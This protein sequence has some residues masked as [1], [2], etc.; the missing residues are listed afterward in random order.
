MKTHLILILSLAL[1]FRAYSVNPYLDVYELPE[2]SILYQTDFQTASPGEALQPGWTIEQ[3]TATIVQEDS[4]NLPCLRI[5]PSPQGKF[6]QVTFKLDPAPDVAVLFVD[7]VIKPVAFAEEP[8]EFID[9]SGSVTGAFRLVKEAVSDKNVAALYVLNGNGERGGDWMD[10][11]VTFPL[12]DDGRPLHWMRLTF[13]Q[14]FSVSENDDE[15]TDNRWDLW[16]N[17]RLSAANLGYYDNANADPGRISLLGHR[18]VPLFLERL[19]VS[20]ENPLFADSNRNGLSDKYESVYGLNGRDEDHDGDGLANVQ[21]FLKRTNPVLADSDRDGLNDGDELM[22]GRNPLDRGDASPAEAETYDQ[23]THWGPL[24]SFASAGEI[25]MDTMTSCS[26]SV[27]SFRLDFNSDYLPT[28]PGDSG[29]SFK[30]SEIEVYEN[31]FKKL[32]ATVLNSTFDD[33]NDESGNVTL[34]SWAGDFSFGYIRVVGETK[35]YGYSNPD[36]PESYWEDIYKTTW[37]NRY[38]C[39]PSCDTCVNSVDFNYDLGNLGI[40]GGVAKI[41]VKRERIS[42]EI[43]RRSSLS[44][45]GPMDE[46]H[47]QFSPVAGEHDRRKEALDWVRTATQFTTFTDFPN[48]N[49]YQIK[50]YALDQIDSGNQAQGE[51]FQTITVFDPDPQA[52]GG[53]KSLRIVEEGE[54]TASKE[55]RSYQSDEGEVW[56]LFAG[57]PSTFL[58]QPLKHERLVES[59]DSGRSENGGYTRKNRPRKITRR[60]IS[61]WDFSSNGLKI[62]QV[63]ETV[64]E[65]FP[66]GWQLVEES[67]DPDGEDLRTVYGFRDPSEVDMDNRTRGDDDVQWVQYPD[68]NWEWYGYDGEGN[69]NRIVRPLGNAPRPDTLPTTNQGFRVTTHEFEGPGYRLKTTELT[70][71]TV[72]RIIF[73]DYQDH[74]TRPVPGEWVEREIVAYKAGATVNDPDNDVTTT[75]RDG[76]TNR[77]LRIE[78][79]DGRVTANQY[80]ENGDTLI[81]ETRYQLPSGEYDEEA[82]QVMH[83]SGTLLEREI[84]DVT[85]ESAIEHWKVE[86][87][88]SRY[89]PLLTVNELTGKAI[90]KEYACCGEPSRITKEDGHTTLYDRDALGRVTAQR[91][92]YQDPLAHGNSLMS[93]TGQQ[94]FQIDG[95]NR[96]VRT[97]TLGGEGDR[98]EATTE[99]N[100]AGQQTTQTSAAG[101]QTQYATI[102]MENGGRVELTSLPKSG[103]D[104]RHRITQNRYDA[105]GA[106]RQSMTYASDEPLATK[107]DPRT[108]VHNILYTNGRDSKG[109][110][111]E[112]ADIANIFDVRRTRAYFNQEGLQ[113]EIIHA[114]GSRLAASERFEY[115][116]DGKLILHIDPDGVT[117]RYAYNAKGERTTTALDLDIQPL[118]ATD[119][120]DY[121][122]D[123]ITLVE[124]SVIESEGEMVTRTVNR[125]YAD[126]GIITT[127]VQETTLD[128]TQTRSWHYDQLTTTIRTEGNHPGS[129]TI[130]TTDPSG[131]Y[132]QQI[133]QEG[134]LIRTNRYAN[135]DTLISWISQAY[136]SYNRIQ[137]VTD[138][139]TGTTTYHYD[140]SGRRWKV[141]APNPGT[142]SSTEGTLDTIYHFDAL[143]QTVTTVK[144]SGGQVHQ[145]Y[146]A[147]GTLHKTYGHQ[148]TDVQWGYNGRGERTHMT[149]WYSHL[150]KPATTRWHYNNRGLLAFKQDALGQRVHYAYTSGGRLQ[151]RTWARGVQT[152]YHYDQASNLAHIEYSDSTPAVHFSYTRFGQQHTVQD[153]GGLL[154]YNYLPDQPT[155]L[156]SETRSGDFQSPPNPRVRTIAPLYS[157]PKTLTYNRDVLDRPSGFQIGTLNH[158]RQDYAVTYGYDHVNRLDR[159]SSGGYD[160]VYRFESMSSTNRLRS[161]TANGIKNTQYQYEAGRDTITNIIN[162]AGP[163]NRLISSYVYQYDSDGHRTERSATIIDPTTNILNPAVTDRFTYDQDTGGLAKSERAND[164]GYTEEYY[165]DKIGNRSSLGNAKGEF[166]LYGVNALNQ[167]SSIWTNDDLQFPTY[168]LDGNR[169]EKGEQE[170]VWDA[171]NRLIEVRER[172]SLSAKYAY[173]HKGRR[174]ARWTKDGVDERYLYQGW[175]LIAVYAPQD[176]VPSERWTWGKDLSGTVEHAGGV[177]GLLFGS[178]PNHRDDRFYSYDA[179]G[180]VTQLSTVNG[181]LMENYEY[182]SFGNLVTATLAS[183]NRFL[184]STKSYDRETRAYYYGYRYYNPSEGNWLSRDPI[185]E[186]GGLN[187][188]GF[189]DNNPINYFDLFGNR[190]SGSYTVQ[191]TGHHIVPVELWEAFGFPEE[192]KKIFDDATIPVPTY[193]DANG[194]VWKHD[195]TAHGPKTGYTGHVRDQIVDFINSKGIAGKKM[196]VHEYKKLAEDLVQSVQG[197]SNSFISGY[198]KNVGDPQKLLNWSQTTAT[199]LAHPVGKTPVKFSGIRILKVPKLR[200]ACRKVPILK[201][202]VLIGGTMIWDIEYNNARANGHSPTAA[203]GIAWAR[204]ADPGFEMAVDFGSGVGNVINGVIYE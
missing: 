72:D 167:Y 62:D 130:T 14:E 169:L 149:T 186:L 2:D 96:R 156:G 78:H 204:V 4:S 152:T 197:S 124:Q 180:N 177:G 146:N 23:G 125:I 35:F 61:H 54:R 75:V 34:I 18:Q 170:L 27:I 13:R 15:S 183:D 1:C 26:E 32:P 48:G 193:T 173:D 74:P 82:R 188:Y 40:G 43:Y 122:V 20:S 89:R 171:E 187:L 176:A 110:Y 163:D 94:L 9:A 196:A 97:Q 30:V 42:P 151:T 155:V 91:T 179:N 86:A 129:W 191:G 145:V 3:G 147:N 85:S 65:R 161:V 87:M 175:N 101:V 99:Y 29:V 154:T 37:F 50:M 98:L 119:H 199:Q 53:I 45:L 198:L 134:Q 144:P 19:T 28:G 194:K 6:G 33:F 90:S 80:T 38:D 64:K 107:P 70:N 137:Q 8:E 113:S 143:G 201:Y 160:F 132:V 7:T 68:G 185:D 182:D 79:P 195:F 56:E 181:G 126:T 17:G 148:T 92:G 60:E 123:R 104:D 16:V 121:E 25:V 131:A 12:G 41:G 5:D 139:R 84:I 67:L 57:A 59:Y 202:V 44:Y 200:A 103:H 153:A 157:E 36:D 47:V 58:T 108:L 11:G 192:A 203:G 115:N 39:C 21:E 178:S 142:R 71:G 69:R 190:T 76:V 106:L 112:Q 141:S 172:G 140:D 120:I 93:R 128:G 114:Y 24:N 105:D 95:L 174:I 164:S 55:Y 77:V 158:P 118:E 116:Q 31:L 109:R 88:D 184:F 111:Q 83:R 165:Y 168:D 22:A 66:W 52:F 117:T 73:K 46:G 133:Y 138:S 150:N 127:T 166:A 102:M 189:I 81:K 10:T 162:H 51:P 63:E 49:G 136:D 159:V 100:L 135:D